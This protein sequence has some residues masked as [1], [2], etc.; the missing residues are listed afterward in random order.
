[1]GRLSI[2]ETCHAAIHR[3]RFCLYGDCRY[4]AV[5]RCHAFRHNRR[6]HF[7]AARAA[8]SS[9]RPYQNGIGSGRSQSRES[10][11]TVQR[12]ARSS[13]ALS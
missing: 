2:Q 7:R 13:Q 10:Y 11:V 9:S 5:C 12:V 4:V 8:R 1:M 6:E 3:S